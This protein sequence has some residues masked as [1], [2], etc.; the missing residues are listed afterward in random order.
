MILTFSITILIIIRWLPANAFLMTNEYAVS[1]VSRMMIGRPRSATTAAGR[2]RVGSLLGACRRW[3]VVAS[4]QR[5]FCWRQLDGDII[6]R[7]RPIIKCQKRLPDCAA[8]DWRGHWGAR[9]RYAFINIGEKAAAFCV[10]YA[11]ISLYA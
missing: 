3:R 8:R 9:W 4:H 11:G 5:H 7:R 6:R 2:W 10:K 1:N